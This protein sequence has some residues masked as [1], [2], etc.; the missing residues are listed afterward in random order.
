DQASSKLKLIYSTDA[1]DAST[2]ATV[3]SWS[4]PVI[5][6]NL[7]SGSN[8]SLYVENDGN[9]GTPDPIHLAYHDTSN[10]DLRYTYL[11]SYDGTPTSVSVDSYNS[12]G[13]LT[14]VK[15]YGGIP[16]I[17]YYNNSENGTRDS[18]KISIFRG[19]PGAITAGVNESGNVTGDWDSITIPANDIPVGG[20]PDFNYV[21]L[22]FRSDGSPV[23]GY[24]SDDI[25]WARIL[26]ELAD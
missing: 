25:E 24:L 26:P 13:T 11:P 8:V 10:A 16:Y 20:L 4:D 6:D 23:I 12:V 15:S 1:I 5:I 3:P 2:P 14:E 9:A 22:G 17:V 18:I 7:Y 21:M 19:T